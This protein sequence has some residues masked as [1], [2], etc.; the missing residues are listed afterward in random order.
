MQGVK[1]LLISG[2]EMGHQPLH[3]ASPAA[4]LAESGHEVRCLDLAVDRLSDA[5]VRWAEAVG[6]SVPMHT[7]LRIGLEAA[8]RVRRTRPDLPVVMYGLYAGLA[9][10]ESSVDAC[11]VGEYER[12]LVEWFR[13]RAPGS[14]VDLGIQEFLPPNRGGLPTLDRYAHLS[15]G[16]EHRLA[17]YVEASHGCRHRCTHCP[18]PVVYGGRYRMVGADTVLVDIDRQVESGARHITFGDP[19]FFNGTTHSL[20]V[21]EAAHA[22]H[23]HLTFDAT[24]KVEHLLDHADLLPGLVASGVL[25]VVSA[26]EAVDD[27]TLDLLRKGHTAEDL[28]RVMAVSHSVGLPLH[29]SWMPFTP[30]T[31]PADVIGIFRFLDR[32]DL[33]AVTD[34][35]QLSIRLLVPPGSLI[36]SVDEFARHIGDY[37]PAL[38]G[39]RWVSEDPRADLLQIEMARI[40]ATD[41]DGGADPIETFGRMWSAALTIAGTDPGEALK[42]AVSTGRPRLTEPWFC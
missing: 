9:S 10:G 16:E 34:P 37:D 6:I 29:P 35:V 22:R 7:A 30:I 33:F 24:I 23:P 32:H 38:L 31:R 21:L 41:A 39:H 15:L 36:L 1:I 12:E 20:R 11:L 19:D 17:G 3:L 25:F 5:G 13:T 28:E 40:A 42:M 2:Y 8:R 26:F 18:I 27:R 4:R 14:R